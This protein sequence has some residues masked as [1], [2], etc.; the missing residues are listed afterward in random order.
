MEK[1]LAFI[2]QIKICGI[3]TAEEAKYL[4]NNNVDYAGFVIFE[5]SKRYVT[6]EQAKEIFDKLNP[7]IKKVAVVVSPDRELVKQIA[8]AG[9]DIIQIHGEMITDRLDA[10]KTVWRAVNIPDISGLK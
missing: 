2:P 5:K 4:N 6:V 7:D 10:P 8:A 3:T 9:F 1:N